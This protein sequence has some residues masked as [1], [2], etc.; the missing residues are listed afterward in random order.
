MPPFKTNPVYQNMFQVMEEQITKVEHSIVRYGQLHPIFVNRDGVILNGHK[1]YKICNKLGRDCKYEVK[2]FDNPDDELLFVLDCNLNNGDHTDF[3]KIEALVLHWEPIEKKRA[4][5]R[6]LIGLKR[7]DKSPLVQINTYG[8]EGRVREILAPLAGVG[9]MTYYHASWLIKNGPI[10]IL[11]KLRRNLISI[12]GTYALLHSKHKESEKLPFNGEVLRLD[13]SV[14]LLRGSF[15]DVDDILI[16]KGSLYIIFPSE[17]LSSDTKRLKVLG[18]FASKSLR[19]GGYLILYCKHTSVGIASSTINKVAKSL[20]LV[21]VLSAPFAPEWLN[22]DGNPILGCA[23]VFLIF[24]KAKNADPDVFFDEFPENPDFVD[25]EEEDEGQKWIINA[26]KAALY[27][28]DYV[29]ETL[30][31]GPGLTICDPTCGKGHLGARVVE[32]GLKFVGIEND[33]NYF[34]MAKNNLRES[35]SPAEEETEN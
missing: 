4:E 33:L 6:K 19:A 28:V 31:C 34:K 20:R 3:E 5:Q 23:A 30:K 15:A 16:P 1:R 8:E 2:R 10:E 21:Q 18:K 25:D 22:V 32:S 17:D 11:A 29:L 24:W 35:L 7:G 27:V 14:L 12:D 9:E 26:E 13:S